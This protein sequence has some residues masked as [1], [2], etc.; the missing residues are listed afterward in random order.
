MNIPTPRFFGA[1]FGR[2]LIRFL[3]RILT[4]VSGRE[5]TISTVY[6][7]TRHEGKTLRSTQNLKKLRFLARVLTRVSAREKIITQCTFLPALKEKTLKATPK[8]SKT[9][10]N[11]VFEGEVFFPTHL[12]LWYTKFI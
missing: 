2:F 10:K 4:R 5:K 11:F 6:I 8:P 7:S 3:A 1:I 9:L 12:G